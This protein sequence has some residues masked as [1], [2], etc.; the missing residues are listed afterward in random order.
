MKILF[1]LLISLSLL[2]GCKNVH[3]SDF[4]ENLRVANAFIDAFYSFN[5]DSLQSILS[6]ADVTGQ[7]IL[8]YQGWAECG[9]YEIID[10]HKCFIKN[11]SIILC[12]VT[13]K[14]DLIG[15]LQI[16]FN[17]TDTFHL[18]IINQK[19][20]SVSTSSND[21]A[22]YYQAKEWV[23]ENRPELI[24]IPCNGIM[25]DGNTP[26]ECV[27]AMVRGFAEYAASENF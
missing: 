5:K 25:E 23:K 3:H 2:S 26:C 16:D 21:P 17:V 19:I 4:D 6:M 10:R 14:D 13:V 15:A 22:Q 18:T 27:Q 11:D 20:R 12:P 9:H 7:S 24:Q 8:Y 1:A